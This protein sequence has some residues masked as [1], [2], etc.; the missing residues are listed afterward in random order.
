MRDTN[1][2]PV[3]RAI[4]TL[5][6]PACLTFL[7]QNAYH[8]NDAWFLGRHGPAATNAMGL[9]MFVMITNFGFIL[10]LARGTQSLMARRFGAGQRPAA[11]RT[12]ARGLALAV[13]VALPLAALEW[14]LAP[15][16]LYAMG[17]RGEVVVAG[18]EYLRT[19]ILFMP[20]LFFAPMLDFA[21]QGLGDTVT[22]FRL[23]CIG[24]VVNLV[25][26]VAL[27]LDEL[28]LHWVVG[29]VTLLDVVLPG[30]GWGAMGAALATG[31]SRTLSPILGFLIM[32]RRYKLD[33]L[34]QRKSYSHDG[35]TMREILRVG[36]PAGSSTLIYGLVAMAVSQVIGRFGQDAFGAYAIGFRGIES[37]SF[38]LVLGL[39]VATGT[40]ASHAVGAGDLERAR[41]AGHF[42]V[43][44]GIGAMLVT[45]TIMLVFPEGLARIFTDEPAIVAITVTYITTMA[46]CQVPQALEM[47]Y[48]EAM[49]GAGSSARTAFISLPGNAL[50][51]PLAWGLAVGLGWGIQGVWY[52]I[53]S[54]AVIKGLGVTWLFFSG[55][56]EQGMQAGR[57]ALDHDAQ[58]GP[59]ALTEPSERAGPGG[60]RDDEG[61][62]DR[63]EPAP[64]V[65]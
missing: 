56:W 25:L 63:K 46:F 10:A 61:H 62:D 30:A 55:R 41:K 32:V 12:L 7:L 51:V 26:N 38:M 19:L 57:L 50:R 31:I 6:G 34:L 4:L 58:D 35:R 3:G 16:L 52:A 1:A 8:I 15:D 20:F 13:K 49:A 5:A 36:V 53:L 33:P 22:P 11:A 45:M 59:D 47:I 48:A 60:E 40:V 14:W 27:V 54:S 39:G 9:F 18:T 64:D 29:D 37:I 44:L 28:P 23:G 42:G 24:V 17:G 2:E 43:L 21:F 65:V